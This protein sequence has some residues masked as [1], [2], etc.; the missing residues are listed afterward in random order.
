MPGTLSETESQSR[1]HLVRPQ[2][3]PLASCLLRLGR[4]YG[5]SASE[6]TLLAGLPLENGLLTPS[7][8][9]RAAGRV[10]L[11][12]RFSALPVQRLNPLLF[13]V[14]LILKDQGACLLTS[15]DVERGKA[16][17]GFPELEEGETEV[18]LDELESRYSGFAVYAR[19]VFRFDERAPQ[20]EKPLEGHWFWSA[21]AQSRPLFRDV[22]IASF[23]SNLFALAMPLFV[24]NVYN[25][26]IPNRAVESL[27]VMALGVL[28]IITADFA[29]HMA[30]GYLVDLAAARTN[31][32]LS[33]ELME[34]I[35]G[36]RA[37]ERP[38]SAGSF[39]STVQGFETVR[40]FISS[41]TVFAYVDFPF[42]VFFLL[43]IALIS[44]SLALPLLVG[45]LLVVLHAVLVQ[46]RM[47]ELSETTNRASAMKNATLVESLVSME[48]LKSQGAESQVQGRWEKTV[49]FL[50]GTNIRLRLLSSSVI[51]GMQWVQLS[52]SVATMILGVYLIMENRISM[53]S[54]IAAYMLSSRAMAPVAKITSLLLQYH[55]A[56]RSLAALDEVMKKPTERPAGTFFISRP[57]LLGSIEFRAVT[58][59]YPGQ[60]KPA[61]SNVSFQIQKGEKVA[62]VG[63]VGSGKTTLGKL[64][65]GLYR[66]QEGTILVDGIDHRQL[67]PAELR[68]RIG[69]VP[70][71]ATL[72][73]GSIRENILLGNPPS[74]DEELLRAARIGG[75]DVFANLCPSGFELQVGER[76]ERLS[77]GQRQAVA[78]ARAVLK[79][80]PV[81]LL[82]EPTASMDS[83]SEDRVRR[84][85]AEFCLDRTLLLV[86]HRTALLELVDRLI[87]LDGGRIVAD[88][89]KES[90][91]KALQ[92]PHRKE[93]S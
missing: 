16:R 45:I 6:N 90:V 2:G 21:I 71:E 10:G 13:P 72:F 88:G 75:V 30:R 59:S 78:I 50:E 81:L 11:S 84:N 12:V 8:L 5:H 83:A 27:W 55:S 49:A 18:G 56:S 28:I 44:W 17:V 40:N 23:L 34:Q 65:L 52:V 82:D 1:I 7:L 80:P 68:K 24:M 63:R 86:T 64:L 69:M 36:M 46:G 20:T 67:D 70:Q 54:L 51:N 61:L 74:T 41:A 37:E 9:A 29:L 26:I 32:R 53:G 89:P 14:I 92:Q 48:A 43:V 66:P 58:F 19:P 73:F 57:A 25:R 79:N 76:G 60:E 39:A 93:A 91:L 4:F 87:V 42:A 31:V 3:G 38:P 35:L 33:G 22:L 85:L 77:S 47:R 15:I 62:L